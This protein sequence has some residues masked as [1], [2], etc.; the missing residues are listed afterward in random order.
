MRV[1]KTGIL[2]AIA[3]L[4]APQLAM[5]VVTFDQLNDDM[6]VV[7]HRVKVKFWTSRGQAMRLVYE[8]AASLCVAAG[9][10]H[11]EILDQ[12]SQAL[13][14]REAANASVRVRFFLEGGEERAECGRKASDKYI[15]QAAERLEARRTQRPAL[16]PSA[17]TQPTTETGSSGDIEA[18]LGGSL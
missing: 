10:T 12:E 7:S 13:Q 2:I 17:S 11:L 9:Y 5:G 4:V 18:A 6:F 1:A 3:V 8:K 16:A 14:E 15:E